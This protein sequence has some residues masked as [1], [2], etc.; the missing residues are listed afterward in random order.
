MKQIRGLSHAI[1]HKLFLLV[2]YK[3]IKKKKISESR[4]TDPAGICEPFLPLCVAL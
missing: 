4:F 2:N 1:K 3:N